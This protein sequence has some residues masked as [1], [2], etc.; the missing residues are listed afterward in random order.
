M[1][2]K[3][4]R[5]SKQPGFGEETIFNAEICQGNFDHHRKRTHEVFRQRLDN[6][7]NDSPLPVEEGLGVRSV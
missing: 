6:L 1:N 3:I 2:R 7:G 4:A 5:F